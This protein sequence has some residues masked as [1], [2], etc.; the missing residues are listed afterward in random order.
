MPC[1]FLRN[2]PPGTDFDPKLVEQFHRD[3][4]EADGGEFGSFE[5]HIETV[6]YDLLMPNGSRRKA[7]DVHV[8]VEFHARSLAVKRDIAILIDRFL[9]AHGIGQGSDITFRDSPAETFFL[10][11]RLVE[12]GPLRR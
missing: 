8:F 10:N 1:L 9:K 3:L 12:G 6:Q 4:A 11:G 7:P 5:I 2:V